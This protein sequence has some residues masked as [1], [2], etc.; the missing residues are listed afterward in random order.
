MK[1]AKK[2]L[3]RIAAKQANAPEISEDMLPADVACIFSFEEPTTGASVTHKFAKDNAQVKFLGGIFSGKL[4]TKNEAIEFATIPSKQQ[5]LA[6]FMSM[7]NA[8]LTQFASAVSSP[9]SGFARALAEVAKKKE[10]AAPVAA[11]PAPEAAAAPAAAT[12]SA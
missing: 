2:T 5:L 10:S 7:C 1:V 11:A 4:L 9:L 3:I 8:P 6:M 12:P